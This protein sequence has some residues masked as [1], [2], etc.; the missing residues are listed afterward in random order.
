MKAYNQR[1]EIKAKKKNKRKEFL[2]N[3]LHKFNFITTDGI[4][5]FSK[6]R[7]IGRNKEKNKMIIDYENKYD[8]SLIKKQIIDVDSK[9]EKWVEKV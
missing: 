7:V 9:K 3:N 5:D 1:P 2:H 8:N 4:A 6:W